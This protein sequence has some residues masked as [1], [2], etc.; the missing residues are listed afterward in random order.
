MG[1]ME[2]NRKPLVVLAAAAVLAVLVLVLG[3]GQGLG[4]NG[5]DGGWQRRLGGGP[6]PAPLRPTGL[7]VTSGACSLGAVQIAVTG[8]CV[9]GVP[10]SGGALSVTGVT[11]Q[12]LLTVS[13]SPVG[14]TVV[15]A[16]RRIGQTVA[17]GDDPLKLT[18]GT[19]G[20]TLAL[21]CGTCLVTLDEEAR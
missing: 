13:G 1:V 9:L 10:A 18:F 20:G 7:S 12:G 6:A 3:V 15:V 4:A 14:V 8:A 19:D 16:G 21:Q 2:E 17:P 5:G 11:R